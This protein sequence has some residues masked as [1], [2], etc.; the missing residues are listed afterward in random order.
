[1]ATLAAVAMLSLLTVHGARTAMLYTP[2]EVLEAV[3][4]GGA[5]L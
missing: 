2:A 1:M 5:V 4:A 3:T